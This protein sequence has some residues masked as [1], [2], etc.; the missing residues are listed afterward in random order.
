MNSINISKKQLSICHK[1]TCVNLRGDITK[2]IV[3]GIAV[4]VVVSG[5]ASMLESSN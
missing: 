5:L 4:L 2:T 3:F 1:G